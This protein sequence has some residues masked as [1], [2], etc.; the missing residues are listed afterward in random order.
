METAVDR[1]WDLVSGALSLNA[2]ILSLGP[3]GHNGVDGPLSEEELVPDGRTNLHQTL[4]MITG[5]L[6]KD[7]ALAGF[8][9]NKVKVSNYEL[10]MVRGQALL[11]Q[12]TPAFKIPIKHFTS[13]SNEQLLSLS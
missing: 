11:A 5:I 13:L 10:E 1:F 6:L 12:S 4:D 3:V 7:W 2:Q 9:P 8:D